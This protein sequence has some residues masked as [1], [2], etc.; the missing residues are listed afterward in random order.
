MFFDP[1]FEA[2]KTATIAGK[3]Q[4]KPTGEIAVDREKKER[5]GYT[6]NYKG[7]TLTLLVRG[8]PNREPGDVTF[9]FK[10]EKDAKAI[11][12]TDSPRVIPGIWRECLFILARYIHEE[13]TRRD[14]DS[15]LLSALTA[16]FLGHNNK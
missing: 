1:L 14:L 5:P 7:F 16:D 2:I 13:S 8:K 12:L 4:W 11:M 6:C 15:Q 10:I 3:M 9:G